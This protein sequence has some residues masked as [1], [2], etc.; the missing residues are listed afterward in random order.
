MSPVFN[1]WPRSGDKDAAPVTREQRAAELAAIERAVA[2]GRVKVLPPAGSTAATQWVR[3][4]L[5]YQ[6]AVETP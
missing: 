4:G 5:R 6:I 1:H 2:A 3:S